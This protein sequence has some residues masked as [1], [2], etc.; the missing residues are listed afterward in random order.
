MK[1]EDISVIRKQE[2]RGIN[3]RPTDK[4]VRFGACTFC[5]G[6]HK[7]GKEECPAWGKNIFTVWWRQSL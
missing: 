7:Q 6:E 1:Q 2:K 3:S 4:V 5:G